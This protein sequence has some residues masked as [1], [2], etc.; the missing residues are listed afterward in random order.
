MLKWASTALF[1]ALH[2]PFRVMNRGWRLNERRQGALLNTKSFIV[3]SF[4]RC[5][6]GNEKGR[7]FL[8][9]QL[10]F[11]IPN[12]PHCQSDNHDLLGGERGF[13]KDENMRNTRDRSCPQS[14]AQHEKTPS[15]FLSVDKRIPTQTNRQLLSLSG[16]YQAQFPKHSTFPYLS[17]RAC[18][19]S[20]RLC[21]CELGT[22]PKLFEQ[23]RP[24]PHLAALCHCY[25]AVKEPDPLGLHLAQR[26]TL[27]SHRC[28][29]WERRGSRCGLTQ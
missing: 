14:T 7:V 9:A 6:T 20:S 23:L 2:R 8:Q 5:H 22:G 25:R 15:Y 28:L 4:V 3:P 29:H 17:P 12:S 11:A 24:P 10:N 1:S 19:P 18:S 27:T 21:C 16:L 13:N 26:L